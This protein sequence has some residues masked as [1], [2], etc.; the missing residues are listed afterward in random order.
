MADSKKLRFSTTTKSWVIFAKILQIGPWVSRIHWCEG[1]WHGSIYV[2]V[3][4][5]SISPKPIHSIEPWTSCSRVRSKR[6]KYEET[7]TQ[8]QVTLAYLK[9]S[10][11][12]CTTKMSHFMQ[13]MIRWPGFYHCQYTINIWNIFCLHMWTS[14]K[15]S[16]HWFNQISLAFIFKGSIYSKAYIK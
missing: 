16:M 14:N 3:R 5:S 2:V 11:L 8:K 13:E 1:H 6:V 10:Q 9:N 15:I 12:A 7:Q 4:L